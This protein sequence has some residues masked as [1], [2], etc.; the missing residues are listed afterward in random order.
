MCHL[1]PPGLIAQL[2]FFHLLLIRDD[3]TTYEY[4]IREQERQRE[5]RARAVCDTTAHRVYYTTRRGG[6][7]RHAMR[8]G[9]P[10]DRA[11]QLHARQRA[12]AVSR[13]LEETHGATDGGE[14]RLWS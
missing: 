11:E 14:T 5:V 13:R 12:R 8:G 4:I 3:I 9:T 7:T 1:L 2:V 6:G 10:C